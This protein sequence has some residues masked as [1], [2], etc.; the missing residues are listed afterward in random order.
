[1]SRIIKKIEPLIPKI[2]S[3][4]RVAAYARV[5]TGKDSMIH[6]LSAQISYYSEYIQKHCEWEY[7]GVYADEAI[8]GTKD[9]RTEF[10]RLLTDC[11][12]GKI[13]MVIAKSISSFAR[14]TVTMLEAV[15]H[16]SILNNQMASMSRQKHERTF[17]HGINYS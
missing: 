1:M 11:R 16:R 10:Q 6:S 9:S 13:D 2:P 5:S 14:N 12:E 7:I 3:K 15:T 8:T 17:C 4:K